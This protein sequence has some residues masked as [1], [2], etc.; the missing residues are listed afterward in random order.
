MR[1]RCAS[2]NLGNLALAFMPHYEI[3]LRMEPKTQS[4]D[5]Q[6]LEVLENGP[7]TPAE[8]ARKLGTAWATA[9]GRLLRLVGTGKVAAI[10]KGRVNIYVLSSTGGP[11]PKTPIWAKIRP[12]GA[13]AKELENYFP[14]GVCAAEMIQTERRES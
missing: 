5:E 2:V 7:A 10:R 1:I 14:P 4:V 11:R 12:L 13:L 6:I 9:Q 3:Y 8:I